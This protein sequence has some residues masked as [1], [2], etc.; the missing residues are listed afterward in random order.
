[1]IPRRLSNVYTYQTYPL[2]LFVF[3]MFLFQLGGQPVDRW[4]H[5]HWRLCVIQRPG[6]DVLESLSFLHGHGLTIS[7]CVSYPTA[8]RSCLTNHPEISLPVHLGLPCGLVPCTRRRSNSQ[9]GSWLVG[10]HSSFVR[11]NFSECKQCGRVG[12][13]CNAW[14]Q[15]RVMS[16]C[17]V[18]R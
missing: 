8:V 13:S 12:V 14:V 2:C 5:L 4:L 15:R 11:P 18:D 6:I 9:G 10:E 3:S 16:S 17:H 1:L 7:N